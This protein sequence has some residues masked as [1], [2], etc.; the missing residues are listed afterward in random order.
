MN[1]FRLTIALV[2]VLACA[3]SPLAQARALTDPDDEDIE[4]SVGEIIIVVA[5]ISS[6]TFLICVMCLCLRAKCS[7]KKSC[8]NLTKVCRSSFCRK[9]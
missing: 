2:A 9:A 8:K 4:P 7:A 3:H 1:I 6:L 5:V